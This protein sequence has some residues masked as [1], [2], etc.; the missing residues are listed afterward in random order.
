MAHII[1]IGN[2]KGGSGK[3]TTAMHI[4]VPLLRAGKRVAS[5]DLDARQATLTRYLQN[6]LAYG[7]GH[8]V[9][10][11]M[12]DHWCDGDGAMDGDVAA[13]EARLAETVAADVVVIDTPGSDTAIGRAAHAFADTL[14]TPIN[15]SFID[16]DVIARVRAGDLSVS[17]LS[18][19]AE[20]VWEQKK[21]RAL[22][23][24]GSLD[25]LV[26][27]NRLSSLDAHNK[28]QMEFVLG[29]LAGR[30]GFRLV[31]GFGERVVFRELFLKGLT[32]MDLAER[33]DAAPLN[34]SHVAARQ[35]VRS[36]IKALKLNP[37]QGEAGG[38]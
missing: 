21:R 4:I 16:L 36:L 13:F 32:L 30:L 14:I 28:R 9:R 10:M 35:E 27:R 5:M 17:T 6:R 24:G 31:P 11:P 8:G 38:P 22:R 3:S 34:L 2:E 33:E 1:V 20:T 18:H 12:P 26:M 29:K 7:D 15:D 23:D 37:G 19:Y 25:W